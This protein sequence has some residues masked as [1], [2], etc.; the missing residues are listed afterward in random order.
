MTIELHAW[1]AP[2][3]LE[4]GAA[5]ALLAEWS[6]AGADRSALPF[7]PSSDVGWF[8]RELLHDHPD[9]ETAS[10]TEPTRSTRPIW[11]ATDPEPPARLVTVRVP[12]D[13]PHDVLESIYGLATKYDLVV[14]VPQTQQLT[15][16][17]AETAAWAS[18]TF[19]PQGAIQAA[20]A[21][22]VGAAMAGVAWF[23]GAPIVSGVLVVVG[24][25]LFVMAVYTFAHEGRR[26]L[27]TRRRRAGPGAGDA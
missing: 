7:E 1:K 23:V 25:F 24:G 9:L 12:A 6:R 19:W 4:P 2:R 21:G 20:T 22:T 3:D 27:G 14:Y 11:L 15:L 17:L 8:H 16:P 10:D 13:D 26:A 5:D 18:A